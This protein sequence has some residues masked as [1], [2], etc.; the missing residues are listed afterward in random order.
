MHRPWQLFRVFVTVIAVSMATLA[1]SPR[2]AEA[3]QMAGLKFEAG[4]ISPNLVKGLHGEVAKA[5]DSVDRW[6]F[7]GFD[8]ARGKMA[9]ITRDCFTG[10]CLTKA[11]KAIG[12]PAGLSI[13]MSGEA[14][15]YNWTIQMYD[16]R[17]G[18]KLNTEKGSCELCGEAEVK[19]TFRSSLKA[20]LIGTALPGA[21]QASASPKGGTKAKPAG[22]PPAGSVP[23]RISVIPADAQIYVDDQPA[24]QGEVT[25]AVGPGSHEVRFHKEGYQGLKEQ[26]MVNEGTKGPV[27]LR[28]HMSRTDPEAVAVTTGVGPIDRLGS[29]RKTYGLIGVVAGAALLGT[30]IYLT[31]IDGE[32]ACASGVPAAQCP[33]VYATGGAGMTLGVAGTVLLT[34]GVTLLSWNALAGGSTP[35]ADTPAD[36]P[37][38]MPKAGGKA[39]DPAVSLSPMVGS[40]GGGLLLHGRF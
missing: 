27:L 21:A 1:F 16:L 8:K 34:G 39:D 11:G 36:A 13:E 26:V 15:I 23:L 2:H 9:P 29:A 20:A 38:D 12:A 35:A 4:K 7:I 14:E 31:A 40:D 6:S 28:V 5:F 18:K 22:P 10:D 25:R 3:A 33:D 19:R 37:T 17:S 32:T 30:G 24:G